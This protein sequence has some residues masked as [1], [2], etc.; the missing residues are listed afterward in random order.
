MGSAKGMLTAHNISVRT[1]LLLLIAGLLVIAI[2]SVAAPIPLDRLSRR[3]LLSG[4]GTL[5]G[6]RRYREGSVRV[7]ALVL[8]KS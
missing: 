5:T 4:H 3:S 1:R 8:P 6:G 2:V 7:E